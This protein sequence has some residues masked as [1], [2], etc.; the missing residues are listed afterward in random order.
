M[1]GGSLVKVWRT[2]RLLAATASVFSLQACGDAPTGQVIAVVN[3]EEITQQEL[4][5]EL[6]ELSQQQAGAKDA[7]R[8]QV[9]QQIIDRRLMA[10]VAKE[11][12]MDRDPL[13][14]IR[15]RRLQ[16]ELLVQMYGKKAA[17]ATRVPDNAAVQ[18]YVQANPGKF[19]ERTA[20]TVSQISFDMPDDQGVLKQLE[21]TK[22]LDE[23]EQK[24]QQLKIGFAKGSGRLDSFGIPKPILNQI[25]ALP[26][27]EPFIIPSQGKVV[28][29]VIT[30]R[31]PVAV[32]E[33]ELA[34][35]AAQSLRAEN[36]GKTLQARLDEA[37]AKAKIT[38]QDG[39]APPAAKPAEK[40]AK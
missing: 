28:V 6:S 16:E 26:A 7:V 10:Q 24:L 39:F 22:T 29:S 25:L 37:K 15:E 33:R 35:L 1:T 18:K 14:I 21:T 31:E 38:Y 2:A 23:V 30:G 8:A 5:A 32:N 19:A 27:G 17:D 34:P 36:L 4:N 20:Y 3:G 13:Y 12:G 9:L 40:T 11:E